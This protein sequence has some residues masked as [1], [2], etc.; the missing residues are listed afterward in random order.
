MLQKYLTP[1]LLCLSLSFCANEAKPPPTASNTTEKKGATLTK[2]EA[3]RQ[4]TQAQEK[5]VDSL[6]LYEFTSLEVGAA[7]MLATFT[8]ERLNLSGLTSLA[9]SAATELAAFKGGVLRLDGVTALDADTAKALSAFKGGFLHLNGLASLDADTAKALSEFPG[10]N[11]SLGGGHSRHGSDHAES[12]SHCTGGDCRT[13]LVL[14]VY[15]DERDYREAQDLG[16]GHG[17]GDN[18]LDQERHGHLWHRGRSHRPYD[19]HGGRRTSG[20][21]LLTSRGD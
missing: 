15:Y 19:I 17:T 12:R 4:I 11:L 14:P 16:G 5:R 1:L 7:T 13:W 21:H 6:S 2:E 10:G 20:L 9:A 8:G 18:S 3:T